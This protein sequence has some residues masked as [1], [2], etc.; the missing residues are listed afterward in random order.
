MAAF[1]F[2]APRIRTLGRSLGPKTQVDPRVNNGTIGGGLAFALQNYLAGSEENAERKRIAD[3]EAAYNAAQEALTRGLMDQ[4]ALDSPLPEGVQGPVRPALP[5]GLGAAAQELAGLEGNPYAGRL[6]S[7]LAMMRMAEAKDQ[8]RYDMERSDRLADREADRA[9]QRE[10]LAARVRATA[11]NRQPVAAPSSVREYQFFN[12][13]PPQEQQ[14][15]LAMK[16]AQQLVDLGDRT[17]VSDPLAPGRASGEFYEGVGPERVVQDDRVLTLPGVPGSPRGGVPGQIPPGAP[18]RQDGQWNF[19][20]GQQDAA[21]RG[22]VPSGGE[23]PGVGVQPLPPSPTDARKSREQAESMLG[24]IDLLLTHPGREAG[25]G[26]SAYVPGF[27]DQIMGSDEKRNFEVASS[28]LEGQAFL[29]AFE[30]LKGGGHITEIEGVK[31][32]QAI[33]RLDRTQGEEAYVESLQ[34]LRSI[35]D[36]GRARAAGVPE[37]Q[38]PP[39][40]VPQSRRNAAQPGGFSIRRID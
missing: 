40:Y 14:R 15:Y 1:D 30:S 26:M 17:V 37:D 3:D 29:Q 21:D 25:T 33:G 4:P 27:A 16:R 32:T 20:P 36:R 5:G 19:A 6:A 34:E 10:M 13:L 24:T 31:A 28:Q 35:I 22:G 12:S 39:I 18:P 7:Q 9:F 38:L 23:A 8:Q 2:G 11:A